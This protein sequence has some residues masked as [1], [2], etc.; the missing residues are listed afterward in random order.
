MTDKQGTGVLTCIPK[1]PAEEFLFT[2]CRR[3][4]RKQEGSFPL[5]RNALNLAKI[6]GS[7]SSLKTIF[8]M[9]NPTHLMSNAI[10]ILLLS[11]LSYDVLSAGSASLKSEAFPNIPTLICLSTAL[12]CKFSSLNSV[13]ARPWLCT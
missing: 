4:S 6:V 1:F 3:N 11:I 8:A 7:M 2:A 13:C 12:M 5:V 9:M 10:I